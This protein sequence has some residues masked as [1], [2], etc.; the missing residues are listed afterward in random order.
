MCG[1]GGI[2]N[3]KVD[4]PVEQSLLVNM[5]RKMVHRG[6]DD[7]GFWFSENKRLGF[8]HRRLSIIDIE[9][10]KQPML[11]YYE[12]VCI[13]YNGEIYNFPELKVSLEKKG[14]KFRTKSDT[15]IIL[16][17]YLEHGIK[18]FSY[19]NGIFAFGIYDTIDNA[20]ILARSRYGVKPLYYTIIDGKR[21]VFASEIKAIYASGL[22]TRNLCEDALYLYLTFRFVPS[23]F[24]MI[25]EIKRL[26]AAHY[27]KIG[28]DGCTTKGEFINEYYQIDSTLKDKECI[29]NYKAILRSS[30]KRQMLSDVPVGLLLSGGIDST[31][32]G[33][34]M[35][36]N[37]HNKIKSFS[38]GFEGTGKYNELLYAKKNSNF[39]NTEHFELIIN[40]KQ[41]LDFFDESLYLLEE[42]IAITSIIAFYFI[43]KLASEHVKVALSGQGADEPL[44]GYN[45]YMGEKILSEY[46]KIIKPL[47]INFLKYFFPRQESLSRFISAKQYRTVPD[48]HLSIN[49][50]FNSDEQSLLIKNY[51]KAD[52]SK[53]IIESYIALCPGLF[54]SLSKILFVDTR[55]NLADN[56]LIIADKMS[57]ANS[58]EVRVPYLDIE[59][60]RFLETIPPDLKIRNFKKK[61]IHKKA[62]T[63]WLPSSIIKRKKLGFE[64]PMDE[65][66]RSDFSKTIEHELTG[67][68]SI[69]K[70]LF[71]IKYIKELIEQHFLKKKQNER[72]I[73]LLYTFEKWYKNFF[74]KL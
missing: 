68:G 30:V 73:F 65:W 20:L 41:Y 16:N 64:T 2:F 19:L 63:G 18:G 47:N 53:R 38:I 9:G 31:T 11:D 23:P 39:I 12:K 74:L 24:T 45:R 62:V 29:E 8:A 72:K 4:E 1:I 51:S 33:Y 28:T 15:E 22:L 44:G 49:S 61:Y 66:L 42:P 13:V 50:I 55:L 54:D 35:K 32:V 26:E 48:R 34:L 6:P 25:K 27:I 71:N 36:R 3:F 46:G 69:C 40:K 43:S 56:L 14:Y 59:L 21:L 58:L 17:I 7:E 52:L 5:A 10:G 67:D 70:E 57:M 37:N 60:I